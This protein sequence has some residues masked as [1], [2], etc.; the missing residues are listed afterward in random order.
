MLFYAI[1]FGK[2]FSYNNFV[3]KITA[4][5]SIMRISIKTKFLILFIT[6]MLCGGSSYASIEGTG[7]KKTIIFYPKKNDTGTVKPN[8]PPLL[9][10]SATVDRDQITITST[11]NVMAHVTV[12]D[13][14]DEECYFE[15]MAIISPTYSF[16][17]PDITSDLL[18]HI[19]IGETEYVGLL[20]LNW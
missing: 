4:K 8:V 3:G 16:C 12:T 5:L 18:L 14:E 13:C 20:D 10:L 15:S 7:N 6:A 17:L 9:Q 19:F 1:K 11:Q 2:N